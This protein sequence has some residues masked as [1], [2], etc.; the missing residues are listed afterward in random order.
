VSASS[1][2]R[3]NRQRGQEGEREIVQLVRDD[4]G[5]ELKGRR[6]GQERDGGHDVD[7]GTLKAQ[8]KRRKRLAGLYE[9][10]EGADVA[11]VRADGKGWLVV[12][13]WK[14]FAKLSRE[15]VIR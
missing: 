1:Q 13:D 3:R 7:I 12:M 10:L 6:L 15:E 11:C 8:V 2:G 4:F 9:W 14:V 5:L